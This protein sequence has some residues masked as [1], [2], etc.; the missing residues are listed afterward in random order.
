MRLLLDV[1]GVC[2][3]F[4]A[5]LLKHI[6]NLLDR[7]D[8][9]CTDDEITEFDIAKAF[10]LPPELV[11]EPV[12]L[13]G[14]C[15]DLKPYDGAA[16]GIEIL[17]KRGIAVR[18]CTT[19]F[20]SDWWSRER[21][22]W[23]VEKLGFDRKHIIQVHEKESCAGAA[24]VDD[25]TSTLVAWQAAHPNDRAILFSR[26]WNLKDKWEGSRVADWPSL[27]STVLKMKRGKKS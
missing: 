6:T 27:V 14:Y 17:R 15:R 5:P 22:K 10:G 19:P 7:H 8:N 2:A 16:E 9:P 20:D 25:K 1:D 23:L 11:Y 4:T 24:L 13:A 3:N 26:P 21:E 18:A 12:G